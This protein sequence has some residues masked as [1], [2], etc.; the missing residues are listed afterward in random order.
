MPLV[1]DVAAQLAETFPPSEFRF[2]DSDEFD[3]NKLIVTLT[4]R[5]RSNGDSH[6][7]I[8]LFERYSNGWFE[9]LSDD[10]LGIVYT[11]PAGSTIAIVSGRVP[12]SAK[13]CRVRL[14]GEERTRQA[15]NGLFLAGFSS[16]HERHPEL[17]DVSL[18]YL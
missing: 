8:V 14:F 15:N 6:F 7:W 9:V 10:E 18:T 13:A 11:Q 2:V 5:P 16:R 4:E 17:A 1:P 3:P 12:A